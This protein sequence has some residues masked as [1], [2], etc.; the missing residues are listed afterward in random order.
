MRKQDKNTFASSRART[1]LLENFRLYESFYVHGHE[2]RR[3]LAVN[4][5]PL[6]AGE[7]T[8]EG[9]RAD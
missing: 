9:A 6:S 1:S 4:G 3:Q 8:V 7:K 2:V 5:L